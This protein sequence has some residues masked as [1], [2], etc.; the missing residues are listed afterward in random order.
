MSDVADVVVIGAGVMGASVA[1]H[2][3]KAGVQ[4]VIV[5]EKRFLAAGATGKSSG[6]VRMHYDNEPESRLAW[7]SFHY[8]R[9][10]EELV[11]GDC[12]FRRTGFVRIV[13]RELADNLRANVAMQQGIGIVTE[14]ISA[15][16]VARVAPSLCIDD[17]DIAA[18][19]PESG[20]ADPTSTTGAF[21]DRARDMGA[22][23]LQGTTVTGIGT[24]GGR[25]SHVETDHG[26]IATGV[27]VNAAGA[28][29][30]R[31]GAM[32]GLEL[33]IEGWRHQVLYL[34]RPPELAGN[35]PAVI[36]DIHTQYFRP[37]TGQ[38][39]LVGLEDGN[40]VG[41]DPD[42]Y[43]EWVDDNFISVAGERLTRRMPAMLEA[44]VGSTQAGCD[45]LTPDQHAIIDQAGPEG[46]YLV[47][48]HSGTGFKISP[49]VGKCMAELITEGST[50]I[51]DIT[52]F[53]FSR[54]AEGKPLVGEHPYGGIWK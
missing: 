14:V 39:T 7:I 43:R 48:G 6:L 52:P 36:D 8:F 20:Y 3:A 41:V 4:K 27:V 13:P 17:F 29:G 40:E 25:V 18:Y 26:V 35:H 30:A 46:F 49:A 53:R 24:D 31:I 11:G 33:P 16:E 1:Y 15:Q 44:R 12:G 50:E 54:Y 42:S 23:L 38:L 19:E 45:G 22:R 21:M 37:E 47:V 5:V 2:L 9:H 28:W 51:M 34:R 10:W 32:V